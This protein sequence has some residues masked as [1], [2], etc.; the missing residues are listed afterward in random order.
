MSHKIHKEKS[1]PRKG[2]KPHGS[3]RTLVWKTSLPKLHSEL[4]TL[5]ALSATQMVSDSNAL[6]LCGLM[7]LKIPIPLTAWK[8]LPH[9]QHQNGLP[10]EY[11]YINE[12]RHGPNKEL[13]K[14]SFLGKNLRGKQILQGT[15][16]RKIFRSNFERRLLK[17]DDYFPTVN[18]GLGRMPSSQPLGCFH[19]RHH[20]SKMS[21][22][23]NLKHE[24]GNKPGLFKPT[25]LFPLFLVECFTHIP[26]NLLQKNPSLP[27]L[28]LELGIF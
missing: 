22:T 13:V 27:F 18:Q 11:L 16:L 25:H 2:E 21:S 23:F 24:D 4:G 5:L 15:N 8:K 20:I 19:D 28:Q 9:E 10:C 26:L 1:R 7:G 17:G 12:K 6:A 3:C 14:T